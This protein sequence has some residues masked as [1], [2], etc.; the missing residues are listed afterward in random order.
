ML[1]FLVG[2]SM[3]M[4]SQ[5]IAVHLK[6]GSLAVFASE[7]VDSITTITKEDSRLIGTWYLG[8]WKSGSSVIKFDGTEYMTFA[9]KKLIWGGKGSDPDT[10]SVKY[11]SSGDFFVAT[12]VNKSSDVLK[13]YITRQTEKLLVLRDGQA[14]RYFYRTKEA[15]D[16]AQMEL[17]PPAHTETSDIKTILR[18]ATGNT[19]SSITPMGKHFENRHETTDEDR[20]WLLN[21]KNEPDKIANLTLWRRK[22]V[23]LYPYG[24]PVPADV[25]Q[26]AIGDCCACAVLA[27]MAYLYPDFIKHIITD[28]GDYTYTVKMYDPQGN[29]IDVGISSFFL[30]DSS[31]TIGQLTGKNNVITW[32]TV[33]EKAII[34]WE[35][36]Y[37]VDGV[38][39]IGT[40]HVAPL[41]TGEGESFAFSPNSLY[42]S[43]LKLAIEYCLTQGKICVGGF[44]VAD[45]QCGQLKT[46]VG[47][48]FTFMF[49]N[50]KSSIF[51]M[52][53][54]WGIED[55]DGVLEIP[56]DRIIVQTIDARIV[57]P[58]AAA[59]YLRSDLRPYSP[60]AFVRKKTDIGVSPRLL[61]RVHN[62]NSTEL[63]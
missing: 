25:N 3:Q 38:E 45:L 51:A 61:N 44:N 11:Y 33:L 43:E 37:K 22:S 35:T 62:P 57:N 17:D 24:D 10:Y 49:S 39:G 20:E 2:L 28:N 31:G 40:E 55:V 56:N 21:P 54:P 13:W 9:G 30:C 5:G 47:H 59:P 6:D 48:A 18:Y 12:N 19:K 46:V 26:H 52:R 53:N 27:S 29:P 58:G 16:N 63:W 14:Y 8:F 50:N 1:T 41:F 60:P 23:K 32:A 15:A 42:T 36:L 7:D 34:K 4:R